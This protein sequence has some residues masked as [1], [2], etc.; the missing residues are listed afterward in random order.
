MELLQL[1][2]VS[3]R[4]ISE[5]RKLA[6]QLPELAAEIDAVLAARGFGRLKLHTLTLTQDPVINLSTRT[7]NPAG[8]GVT[9]DGLY[10]SSASFE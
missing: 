3:E 10:I 5:L 2:N 9:A 1:E 7:P 4:D 8:A 6:T